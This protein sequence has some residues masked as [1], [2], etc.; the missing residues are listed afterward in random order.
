MHPQ[1]SFRAA[2][3]KVLDR[4]VPTRSKVRIWRRTLDEQDQKIF[5]R[6]VDRPQQVSTADLHRAI[7]AAGGTDISYAAVHWYRIAVHD[8]QPR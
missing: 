5:D 7:V 1:G 6:A 3:A 2:L 4:E 8:G